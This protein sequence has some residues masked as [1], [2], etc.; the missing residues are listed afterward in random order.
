MNLLDAE[1]CA[2]R[3]MREHGLTVPFEWHRGTR[4]VAQTHFTRTLWDSDYRLARITFSRAMAQGATEEQFRG[5]MLHEIAHALLP[6]RHGHDAVWRAL[7]ERIGGIAERSVSIIPPTGWHGDCPRCGMRLHVARLP[8]SGGARCARCLR[9]G[10]RGDFIVW[11]HRD[12]RRG[13]NRSSLTR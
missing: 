1:R 6:A 9:D 2:I 3:L 7:C 12:G 11:K 10:H 8:A 13:V 5:A 4:A